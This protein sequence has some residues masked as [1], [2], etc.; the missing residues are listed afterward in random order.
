M[1]IDRARVLDWIGG[2]SFERV[3]RLACAATAPSPSLST[4]SG[5]RPCRKFEAPCERSQGE[6]C[7]GVP[8]YEGCRCTRTQDQ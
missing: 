8:S 5:S 7:K 3:Q 4:K 2:G 1:A 6:T